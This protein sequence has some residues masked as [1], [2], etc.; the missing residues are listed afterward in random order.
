MVRVNLADVGEGFEPLPAGTYAV[1]IDDGELRDSGENAKHPGSQYVNWDLIVTQ[2]DYEGR[3][4][5][6]NTIVSHGECECNDEETFNKGMFQIAG[7][8]KASGRY[9]EEQLAS[10]DFELDIDDLVG[11][12]FA[13]LLSVR[14][15]EEFGDSNNVKRFR[16]I[17]AMASASA[18]SLLP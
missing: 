4:V 10:D 6:A 3:H 9:D 16:P 1:R 7:L 17:S 13:A 18:D 15:S 5:F 8:L 12:E 11:S 14:K 2:G